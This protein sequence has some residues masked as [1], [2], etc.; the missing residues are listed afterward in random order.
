[1]IKLR[2][3]NEQ[4]ENQ[5]RRIEVDQEYW[6]RVEAIVEAANL[7]MSRVAAEYEDVV[8]RQQEW[9][10][11][12]AEE[13]EKRRRQMA[14]TYAF[15][16]DDGG[17][18]LPNLANYPRRASLLP[19]NAGLAVNRSLLPDE[20]ISAEALALH[21][22]VVVITDRSRFMLIRPRSLA[23]SFG[24]NPSVVATSLH[25]VREFK[26]TAGML[27]LNLSFMTDGLQGYTNV[28][29]PYRGE[30]RREFSDEFVQRLRAAILEASTNHQE[31]P[32]SSASVVEEL[33]SLARLHQSGLLTDEEWNE[34]KARLLGKL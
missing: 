20:G 5:S 12:K 11:R 7:L 25:Q 28:I 8:R 9:A 33:E 18:V 26:S 2:W 23:M 17:V 32:E 27:G 21:N 1:M 34:A 13:T 10:A 19:G 24:K 22:T 31:A 3:I 16:S 30:E 6:P 14:E 15:Y 4:L 29:L